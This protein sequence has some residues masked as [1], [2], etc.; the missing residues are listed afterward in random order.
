MPGAIGT[1][2][3]IFV[4]PPPLVAF[5]TDPTLAD[6]TLAYMSDPGYLNS[7]VL[8]SVGNSDASARMTGLQSG[9]RM[10]VQPPSPIPAFVSSIA[11]SVGA[12]FVPPSTSSSS[13]A[14][15]LPL[16]SDTRFMF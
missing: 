12:T 14:T 3:Y 7:P 16:N 8:R 13:V 5:T 10:L 4:A 6:P 15:S 9:Y 11:R 2:G 1:G